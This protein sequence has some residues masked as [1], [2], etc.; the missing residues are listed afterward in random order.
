[1]KRYIAGCICFATITFC[2]GAGAFAQ[3]H[4]CSN[5]GLEGAWAYTETGTVIAPTPTGGTVALVAAA[6]GRYDF[7]AVGNFTGTQN[8]SAGG[9]VSQDSKKGT[10]NIN[11]DCTGT[12]TLEAYDPTGTTLRRRSV[13][14]IVLADN[15][16]EFR[17][18]M[19]SMQMPNGTPLSPIMTVTGKRLVRDRGIEP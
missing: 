7:D 14:Y 19:T 9:T 8:S 17:G 15:A 11:A 13:W 16:T 5:P 2:L 3:D 10:Y 18:I 1:M 6:V 12:L 4:R